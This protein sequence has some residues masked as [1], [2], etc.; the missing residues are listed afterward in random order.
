M[1]NKM[2][3]PIA[4]LACVS[5]SAGTGK[6]VKSKLIDYKTVGGSSLKMK[7]YYPPGWQP[8]N[9]K[10]PAIVFFFGGGWRSGTI[11]H[12]ARQ[13]EYL[14]N[15]G[16]IAICPQYRTGKSHKVTPDKCVEDAKSAMRYVYANADK[17]GVDKARIAAGGGSAG[18]QLAAATAF[19]PGFD[20][21]NEDLKITCK[22]VA[23]VLFNPAVDISPSGCGYELVKAYW[24]NFSPTHNIGPNKLPVL[25]MIGDRD[26][27]IPLAT[28]K[29][30]KRKIEKNGGSCELIIYPGAGHGFF[31]YMKKGIKSKYFPKTINDMDKFLVKQGFITAQK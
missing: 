29:E 4:A 14:A 15:R 28:A 23:L 27:L 30:F 12:F 11:D 24:R 1:L 20:A 5:L 7:I 31:N 25:F 18:G 21:P 16:M 10:L 26:R 13:A 9:K 6:G 3:L 2:F 19:C 22:P 8:G 17:L